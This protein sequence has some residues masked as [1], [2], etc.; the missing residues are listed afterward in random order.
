MISENK[1]LGSGIYARQDREGIILTTDDNNCIYIPRSAF[2]KLKRMIKSAHVCNKCGFRS[3]NIDSY[4]TY[5]TDLSGSIRKILLCA[6]C[7]LIFERSI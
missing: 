5:N 2:L 1:S 4:K 6:S 7:S 3:C